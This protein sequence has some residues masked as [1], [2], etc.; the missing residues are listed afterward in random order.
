MISSNEEMTLLDPFGNA[1][2]RFDRSDNYRDIFLQG[3][4]DTGVL[5]LCKLCGWEKELLALQRQYRTRNGT[6]AKE[7]KR[8]GTSIPAGAASGSL[9]DKK[10]GKITLSTSGQKSRVNTSSKA[11]VA[12]VES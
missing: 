10:R 11:S 2:F 12:P 8:T 9:S 7:K 1:G 4:C 6:S 3:D 5:Q